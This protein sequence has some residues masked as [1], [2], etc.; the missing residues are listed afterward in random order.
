MKIQY[1]SFFLSI[2]IINSF[3]FSFRT[4]ISINN[5]IIFIGSRFMSNSLDEIDKNVLKIEYCTGCRWLLRSSKKFKIIFFLI[6]ENICRSAWLAQEILTTFEKDMEEVALVP[7]CSGSGTFV[8]RL[9]NEVIWDRKDPLT[10]G[11]PEAKQLKQI[12]RDKINP[13][14]CL[15]HSDKKPES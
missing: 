1:E 3:S 8:I 4:A 2:F 12:I 14:L 9:N 11:F 6:C 5:K 10:E 15:G 7:S 13:G